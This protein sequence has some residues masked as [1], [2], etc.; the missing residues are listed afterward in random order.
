MNIK[1]TNFSFYYPQKYSEN[2]ELIKY[3]FMQELHMK[4]FKVDHE[5]VIRIAS[6]LKS[7]LDKQKITPTFNLESNNNAK[8]FGS[9]HKKKKEFTIY[10]KNIIDQGLKDEILF[11]QIEVTYLHELRHIIDD[12]K[13]R[14]I[15]EYLCLLAVVSPAPTVWGIITYISL[16]FVLDLLVK[17]SAEINIIQLILLFISIKPLEIL[18]YN[19]NPNEIKARQFEKKYLHYDLLNIE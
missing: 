18:S 2:S 1:A 12:N 5:K 4:T 8:L 17:K 16:D 13:I 14:D 15:K 19:F 10:L 7:E 6:K 11:E 9:Y 3:R